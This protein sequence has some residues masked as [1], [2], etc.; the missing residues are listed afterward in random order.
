MNELLLR[1]RAMMG[2]NR[3]TTT[4][5]FFIPANTEKEVKIQSNG[6][7]GWKTK[8][9]N[10]G[11]GTYDISPAYANMQ[12]TYAPASTAREI[13][14]KIVGLLS[15]LSCTYTGITSLDVSEQPELTDLRCHDNQLTT[16]D[17]SKCPKLTKLVCAAN[18][19]TSLDVSLCPALRNL[20]CGRNPLTSLDCSHNPELQSLLSESCQLTTLDVSNNP[21]LV[22]LYCY[23]NQ[24]TALDV[25]N[26]PALVTLYCNSNQL[27]A[28]DV[29]KCPKISTLLCYNNKTFTEKIGGIDGFT[30]AIKQ[31]QLWKSVGNYDLT[32]FTFD[33]DTCD[34][35]LET[36]GVVKVNAS[37]NKKQKYSKDWLN[38]GINSWSIKAAQV[39]VHFEDGTVISDKAAYYEKIAQ[40]VKD[41]NLYEY[42]QLCKIHTPTFGLQETR[43]NYATHKVLLY[44]SGNNS[45]W[46]NGRFTFGVETPTNHI[47]WKPSKSVHKNYVTTPLIK[48]RIV[49]SPNASFYIT[50]VSS[51]YSA[52]DNRQ[53]VICDNGELQV[54]NGAAI[55][56]ETTD[57][58]TNQ[59]E[60]I[61]QF[62]IVNQVSQSYYGH[63][64][65]LY[66]DK[67]PDAENPYETRVLTFEEVK[68]NS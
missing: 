45:L 56:S 5:K 54:T 42:P 39:E 23:S 46:Q 9:V 43:D 30:R 50:V 37:I 13:V 1:R 57:S 47:D 36:D 60:Y 55:V 25:S 18:K 58:T 32:G 15:S 62:D 52:Y 63:I 11:D 68:E 20:N 12:H 17:V 65:C 2:A 49:V 26:N 14:V 7:K 48:C 59:T 19:L 29:S 53:R 51:R 28:L 40:I 35:A 3:P 8:Y 21:A 44:D 31:Y 6:A 66:E 33:T 61:V 67:Y 22:T 41:E 4:L 34:L 27:T 24:L 10:W 16:L 38:N 64:Y